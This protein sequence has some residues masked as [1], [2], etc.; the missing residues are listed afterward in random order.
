MSSDRRKLLEN[1]KVPV[2]PPRCQYRERKERRPDS[3]DEG[4][5]VCPREGGCE[6]TS[7][8]AREQPRGRTKVWGGLGPWGLGITSPEA[9]I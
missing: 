2:S 5:I 9:R 8:G 4:D 3:E 1:S 6:V 7:R